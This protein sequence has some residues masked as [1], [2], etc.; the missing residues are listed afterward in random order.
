MVVSSSK[1]VGNELPVR[2]IAGSVP[3]PSRAA[4]TRTRCSPPPPPPACGAESWKSSQRL[5]EL[6]DLARIDGLHE[7]V[8]ES[9]VERATALVG[10][11]KTRNGHDQRVM[12]PI[13]FTQP[14][15]HLVAVE[16]RHG[17]VE[18]HGVGA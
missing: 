4:R 18:Q 12:R 10:A 5:Q 7:V 13:L 2:V 3:R 16:I 15:A 8:I 14:P 6:A 17:D 1:D 9:G 11:A